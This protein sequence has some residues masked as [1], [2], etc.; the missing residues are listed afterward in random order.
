M[1][2]RAKRLIGPTHTLKSLESLRETSLQDHLHPSSVSKD[3]VENVVIDMEQD[4]NVG[5]DMGIEKSSSSTKQM[6]RLESK[7]S[8]WSHSRLY[9]RMFFFDV[10]LHHPNGDRLTST[11]AR[12]KWN[13]MRLHLEK[14]QYITPSQVSPLQNLRSQENSSQTTTSQNKIS[15]VVQDFDVALVQLEQGHV[16]IDRKPIWR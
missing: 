1:N 13:P 4:M 16:T 11:M 15:D 9:A 3:S 12:L 8:I 10:V 5:L 2:L 7:T 14:G 6:W